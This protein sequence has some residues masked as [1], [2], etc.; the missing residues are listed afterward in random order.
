MKKI[1][2]LQYSN[3]QI[4][5]DTTKIDKTTCKIYTTLYRKETETHAYLHYTSAHPTHCKTWAPI[6]NFSD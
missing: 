1:Y 5:F 4:N 2:M 6:V 3:S